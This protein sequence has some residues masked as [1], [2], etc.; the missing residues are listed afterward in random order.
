[1]GTR[2]A[3]TQD[4]GGTRLAALSPGLGA[5]D[6]P[7]RG[8]VHGNGCRLDTGA[9]RWHPTPAFDSS[10]ATMVPNTSQV[11]LD[12]LKY[13][14]SFGGELMVVVLDGD[15]R[16]L[17]T[18][19]N[20]AALAAIESEIAGTGRFSTIIGPDTAMEFAH[21]QVDIAGPLMLEPWA[22]QAAAANQVERDALQAA[23]RAGGGRRRAAGGA[24]RP[25]SDASSPQ[26]AARTSGVLAVRRARRGQGG[27]R[28]RS[29][30]HSCPARGSPPGQT[31]RSRSRG[32]WRSRTLRRRR[33]VPAGR[34]WTGIHDGDRHGD[35]RTDQINERDEEGETAHSGLYSLAAMVAVLLLVFRARWR[36]APVPVIG[37][38]AMIWAFRRRRLPR[39]RA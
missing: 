38:V 34:R 24:V 14:Q 22:R 3:A 10:Q 12:N 19:R 30:R 5:V 31:C 2:D 21:R 4:A 39:I 35:A 8:V 16:R 27:E 17:F 28:A 32:G 9:G 37:P 25:A 33:R 20:R 26:P 1:M 18:P 36:L 29:R 15:V 13:Q 7:P 23:F 6:P 11:Y